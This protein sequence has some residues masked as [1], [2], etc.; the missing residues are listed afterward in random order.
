MVTHADLLHHSCLVAGDQGEQVA[1]IDQERGFLVQIDFVLD[2]EHFLGIIL[3]TTTF[4]DFRG[5]AR[6]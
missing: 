3:P 5:E 2:S 1:I 6:A 4:E